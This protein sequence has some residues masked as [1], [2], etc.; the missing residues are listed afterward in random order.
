MR[1]HGKIA[2]GITGGVTALLLAGAGA[3]A[4]A[5]RPLS[6]AQV[7][8]AVEERLRTAVEE[9]PTLSSALLTVYSGPQDRLLQY[10]VGTERSGSLVPARTDSP[11]HSASV[12][13]TMLATVYGQLVDE[14]TLTFDDP[15][16]PWLDAETL[17]GL[18]VVDGTDHASEVTVGQLLS[19]TSGAAD[20][21]E[22]PVTSGTPVLEQVAADPD[23]LFT[24]QELI[25]FSRDHQEP[26][27][28][29]GETFAYSDTG[30]V[31]LGLALE[32]IEGAPYAQVL[33]DRLFTPLGMADSYLL[34]EF[35]EGTDILS[36]TADGVDIS[37]RNALSVDWAGGG[38][39]TTMDDLLL[40]LRALTG[41][42][43]VSEETL[44]GLTT[45]EHDL[46]K[47]IGYGMG[48]M[49]LRFSELS[50]LLF[51]MPDVHGA[52]GATGTY[53]LYDPSGDTYYIANFG[54]LDYRQKAIEELVQ[55][56]L[57]VDRL[58]D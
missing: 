17:D 15:V 53:A 55:V 2:W 10:A 35:G 25:A 21:F 34:S 57:L 1:R 9:E 13:K 29:P 6:R 32:R 4:Y 41:N 31:L 26:V 22:G 8:Q 24:P 44:A 36:L 18:F 3:L 50:P 49:Q 38:V 20:Y 7:D 45:F 23:H 19:H 46:D 11:Y 51:A 30:Y 58:K 56:R 43:L 37:R 12:G 27:G 14:G 48:V 52:V 40:F 16:A 54:S 5:N 42:H 39:V 47:G 33:D 28:A